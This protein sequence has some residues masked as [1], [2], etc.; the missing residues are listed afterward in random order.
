M[1]SDK[2]IN[3]ENCLSNS[4]AIV[5]LAAQADVI[6]HST[7]IFGQGKMVLINHNQDWYRLMITKQGKLILTK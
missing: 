1:K 6:L 3:K 2:I 7:D 5:G 4:P